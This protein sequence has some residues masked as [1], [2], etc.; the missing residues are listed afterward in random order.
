MNPAKQKR[1][2]ADTE[3]SRSVP[4]LAVR[5]CSIC[6]RKLPAGNPAASC[7]V[8]LIRIALDPANSGDSLVNEGS[9]DES[10]MEGPETSPRRFGHYEILARP[11]GSLHE[12]G[13]GNFI[14]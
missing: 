7:P 12:L 2:R 4:Q 9:F 10:A 5:R 8:C 14:T 6:G 3:I 1:K 11:D 13:H